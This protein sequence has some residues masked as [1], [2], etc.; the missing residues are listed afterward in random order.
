MN[1]GE[2]VLVELPQLGGGPPK[3]RPALVL[4]LRPGP[5]Q[6]VLICGISTQ[7]QDLQANW[8]ESLSPHDSDFR[9]SGLHRVSAIRLS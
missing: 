7:L 5:L 3:L 9:V 8:D 1:P 4:A 2:V 6:D